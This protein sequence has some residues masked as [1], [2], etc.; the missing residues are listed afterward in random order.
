MLLHM[1]AAQ[2]S[3]VAPVGHW[4]PVFGLFSMYVSINIRPSLDTLIQ[5]CPFQ[6]YQLRILFLSFLL[7]WSQLCVGKAP[8]SFDS[9]SAQADCPCLLQ[10]RAGEL[11]I[12]F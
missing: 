1:S 10:S 7:G 11:D 12:M 3:A 8:N 2:G 6:C 9:I 4:L 5:F